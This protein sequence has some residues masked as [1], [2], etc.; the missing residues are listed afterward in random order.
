ML[1][2]IFML[3]CEAVTRSIGSEDA[4]NKTRHYGGVLLQ[5]RTWRLRMLANKLRLLWRAFLN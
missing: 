3:R 4:G 2:E 1:A 5:S